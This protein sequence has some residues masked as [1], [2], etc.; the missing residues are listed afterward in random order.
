MKKKDKLKKMLNEEQA[1]ALSENQVAQL[2]QQYTQALETEPE[3]SLVVDPENKYE[4][5]DEHKKFIEYYVQFKSVATAAELVGIDMN[6][7]KQYYVAYS[8][9][10]EVRRINRALYHRQFAHKMLSL[11]DIGG[12]L[13]SLL[14]DE[15]VPIADQLKTNDKLRVAG[16]IVELIKLK[17]ESMVDPNAIIVRDI[18]KQI[19]NLSLDTIKQL[20]SQSNKVK[21]DVVIVE[22]DTLTPEEKEY[23]Q[24]L[25]TEELLNLLED[26]NANKGG[27]KK[28]E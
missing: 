3:Y 27:K 7:A 11:D 24:T 19:K 12:Y 26:T 20:L 10:Q 14:T 8:T 1:N 13:S 6:L 18:D 4:L 21:E 17:R 9:Q 5:S 16:M 25:S 23:L 28:D 15:N 22:D 2:Q